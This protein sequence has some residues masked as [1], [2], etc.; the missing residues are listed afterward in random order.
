MGTPALR[1]NTGIQQ[2]LT[3]VL[4]RTDTYGKPWEAES[5]WQLLVMMTDMFVGVNSTQL[6]GTWRKACMYIWED[7]P[8]TVSIRTGTTETMFLLS[9]RMPNL[10]FIYLNMYPL[11][12]DRKLVI[13]QRSLSTPL[14]DFPAHNG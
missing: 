3:I 12:N 6:T 9:D 8:S 13:K 4:A 2:W 5:W 10:I 14:L 11:E 7:R 1:S